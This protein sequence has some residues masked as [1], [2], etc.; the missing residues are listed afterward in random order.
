MAMTLVLDNPKSS[1]TI[2]DDYSK[3]NTINFKITL[4][5]NGPV[6]LTLQIPIGENGVLRKAEDAN[7]IQI[8]TP[9]TKPAP[10]VLGANTTMKEWKLGDY[11][12]GVQ[13]NGTTTLSVSI[14]NILC[15]AS[16][17]TSSITITGTTA[18][19][20][21]LTQ[22]IEIT[23]AKPATTTNPIL[24]FT[25][26]PKFLIGSGPVTLRWD[27]A[28]GCVAKSLKT[29]SGNTITF[30]KPQ[31]SHNDPKNSTQGDYTLTVQQGKSD[32]WQDVS[33]NVLAAG[34]HPL[35]PLGEPANNDPAGPFPS[36]IFDPGDSTG[37]AL[38]A[39]LVRNAATGQEAVLCKSADGIT[40]WQVIGENVPEDM[41]SSPGVLL[42]NRLWLIG[43]SAVDPDQK[44]NRICYYD[45]SN[46]R[47]G[48]RDARVTGFEMARMGHACV[49]AKDKTIWVLGGRD[50]YNLC[51]NDLWSLTIAD[52]GADVTATRLLEHCEWQP[53][54]MFSALEYKG[55][56]WVCGGVSSPN[57]DPLGDLWQS[58]VSTEKWGKGGEGPP[59]LK[60]ASAAG[61][62][63]ADSR[64]YIVFRARKLAGKD[65]STEDHMRELTN[66]TT[67]SR[68]WG[69]P[70]PCT[71]GFNKEWS[72]WTSTPC[73][74]AMVGFHGR[75]YLRFLHR[76]ALRGKAKGAPM[77]VYVTR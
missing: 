18:D 65:W 56:V 60:D 40:D 44:S 52:G 47:Y 19:Q 9:A 17:G 70:I 37:D 75:L 8:E 22:G 50:E 41:Q 3:Q 51:V 76:N 13:V 11:G 72:D 14:S 4:T 15:R 5:G 33:V 38:Y 20:P 73:S 66:V 54:C 63:A 7:N 61:L 68:T 36:V 12:D 35:F 32:Y 29:P 1:V 53:R 55:M 69:S 45:L 21:Q 77:F 74:I 16:E 31:S 71:Y 28:A 43:G 49:V 2:G 62:A 42:G 6:W 27:L 25:A 24:Y 10:G 59:G 46:P 26:D 48:W 58:S 23:K 34:W 30:P 67:T 57:G 39:I 64:F